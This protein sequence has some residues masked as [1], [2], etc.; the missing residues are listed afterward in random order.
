VTEEPILT[1]TDA[2]RE[3][4]V[5]FRSRDPQPERL[6]LWLEVTGVQ[7]DKYTY[8]MYLE[9]TAKA[10]PDHIVQHHDDLAIVI[11]AEDADK[12]RGA[13]LDR[14]GDLETGGII[15]ENPNRPQPASPA[16]GVE[17]PDGAS[18]DGDLAGQI[19]QLLE[20]HIN[21]QIAS[22]GGR[23]DLAGVEEDE[24]KVYLQLSGGCQ[25]CGMAQVTLKQ[26]IEQSLRQA[27]PQITEV[28]DVTDHASGTNPYY[29]SSKK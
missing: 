18:L 22:H 13:V 8:N 28:V 21:P 2:G 20:A 25:G 17:M 7:Q 12:L 10:G 15:I 1:L 16:V 24:G 9:E 14:R 26:G 5:W 3:K 19:Q 23:A 6:A 29:A 11:R 4:A 27:L